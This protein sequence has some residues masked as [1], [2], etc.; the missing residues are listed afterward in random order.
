MDSKEFLDALNLVAK[1]K[2]IDKE[3]IF[4]AIEA[5]L[6]SACKK[7]FGTSQNIKVIIDRET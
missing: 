5:S 3:V 1:E 7:N 4:E 6:V 2:G